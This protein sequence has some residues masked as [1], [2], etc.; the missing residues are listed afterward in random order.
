MNTPV[1]IKGSRHGISVILDETM[2]FED[3]KNCITE[4]FTTSADFLGSADIAIAF[5]GRHLSNE[6][7]DEV[8]KIIN[9]NTKLNV[10]YVLDDDEE[11]CNSFNQLLNSYYNTIENINRQAEEMMSSYVLHKGNLR[12]GQ[13]LTSKG[14]IVILGD[15]N[16]GANVTALGNV[17]V[18]GTLLGTV[19]AGCEGNYSSFVIA[20]DMKPTQIRIGELIARSADKKTPKLLATKKKPEIAYS[21]EGN[22]YIEEITREVINDIQI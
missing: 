10:V 11:R 7:V 14:D 15:V 6:E 21:S 12:S 1:I 9:E 8:L 5:E 16:A 19:H 20:L 18:I 3:L 17:I 4:K 22:I 13:S 2:D